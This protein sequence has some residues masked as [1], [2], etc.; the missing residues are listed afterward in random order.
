VGGSVHQGHF[1]FLTM[2]FSDFVSIYQTAPTDEDK[3]IRKL[4]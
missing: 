1:P 4:F 2:I 3:V